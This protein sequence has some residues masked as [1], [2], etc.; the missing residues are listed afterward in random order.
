MHDHS[1][2]PSMLRT[3]VEADDW[4]IE[5]WEAARE[6]GFPS[7]DASLVALTGGALRLAAI[8][9]V[10]PT[11][12]SLP[13]RGIPCGVAAAQLTRAVLLLELTADRALERAN[14]ALFEPQ[15]DP[16]DRC[17]ASVVVA[18]VRGTSARLA[19]AADCGAWVRSGAGWSEAFPGDMLRADARSALEESHARHR[20]APPTSVAELERRLL[21]ADSAWHTAP[22]GRYLVPKLE[23][24]ECDDVAELVLASDGA[25]LTGERV[26]TGI[27]QWLDQLRSWERSQPPSSRKR[28]DDVV[29]LRMRRR[30]R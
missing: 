5:I 2:F 7:E 22:V 20:S 30:M 24:A 17:Q 27:E 12:S 9:G 11:S 21:R 16:R 10:T 26:A 8:D 19:R 25:R 1:H 29:V 28:H 6:R 14:A 3:T 23:I 18:D 4:T 13:V 15:L